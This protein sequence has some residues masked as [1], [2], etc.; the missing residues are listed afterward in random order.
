MLQPQHPSPVWDMSA[1]EWI[2]VRQGALVVFDG[3]L[4]HL[5]QASRSA[6]SRHAYTLHAVSGTAGYAATNWIQR[7]DGVD[8]PFTGFG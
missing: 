5:S 8:R 2:E 3:G 6:Q 1:L 4:P 7:R